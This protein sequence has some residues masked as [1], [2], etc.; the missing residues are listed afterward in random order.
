MDNTNEHKTCEK[1]IE[2]NIP[3]KL[4]DDSKSIIIKIFETLNKILIMEYFHIDNR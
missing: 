2:I 1:A 4:L 3:S